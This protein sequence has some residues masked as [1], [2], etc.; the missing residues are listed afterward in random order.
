V[1]HGKYTG[2]LQGLGEDSRLVGLVSRALTSNVEGVRIPGRVK[3]KTEKCSPAVSLVSV[4]SLRPKAG[5]V[6]LAFTV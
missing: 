6:V 4:H 3:S 1:S 5:L 2:M